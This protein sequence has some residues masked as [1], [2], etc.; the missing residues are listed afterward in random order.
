MLLINERSSGHAELVAE[1]H[2]GSNADSV[3]R[4]ELS[5][6]FKGVVSTQCTN[7]SLDFTECLSSR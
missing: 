2:S 6:A 5:L 3:L 4:F 7:L 1:D